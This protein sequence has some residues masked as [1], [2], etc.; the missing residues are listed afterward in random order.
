MEIVDQSKIPGVGRIDFLI[1][2]RLPRAYNSF[3]Y[4]T[5]IIGGHLH[6]FLEVR[7]HDI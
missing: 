1:T 5:Y 7:A 4:M 6:P 2:V 3:K